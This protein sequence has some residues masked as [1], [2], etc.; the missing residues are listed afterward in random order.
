V[1][2]LL[3]YA[4]ESFDANIEQITHCK[5]SNPDN[6]SNSE[7][8]ETSVVE[9]TTLI[10]G[11]QTLDYGFIDDSEW[12]LSMLFDN[13]LRVVI[14]LDLSSFVWQVHHSAV[15]L[16][17]IYFPTGIHVHAI[18]PARTNA[19]V[20]T[21]LC[22]SIVCSQDYVVVHDHFNTIVGASIHVNSK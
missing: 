22:V 10:T 9:E 19:S 11:L 3:G 13:S 2:R 14:E 16:W 4:D 7:R 8:P 6:V 18:T 12:T 15:C 21:I 5:F 17:H 1:K 20:T